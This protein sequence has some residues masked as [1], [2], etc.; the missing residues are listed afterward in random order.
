MES[1][2]QAEE[3]ECHGACFKNFLVK[4]HTHLHCV[5]L[6]I[7]ILIILS[8]VYI[9]ISESLAKRRE[10]F[11]HEKARLTILSFGKTAR[12]SLIFSGK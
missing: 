11:N 7:A 4:H 8:E 3:F 10:S 5:I 9:N 6:I 2:E 1:K 12:M